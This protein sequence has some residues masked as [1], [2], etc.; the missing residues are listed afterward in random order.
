MPAKTVKMEE[1][2]K[3]KW[4][5]RACACTLS[6]MIT[7]SPTINGESE[8]IE[9]SQLSSQPADQKTSTPL[10]DVTYFFSTA[11][12]FL[13]NYPFATYRTCIPY[14]QATVIPADS[15]I[16]AMGDLHGSLISFYNNMN[17]LL[18][19]GFYDPYTG[20]LTSHCFL[21]FLGDYTDRGPQGVELWNHLMDL[22]I[23]NKDQVILLRGNHEDGRLARRCGF[24]SEWFKKYGNSNSAR[25]G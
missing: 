19:K 25:K 3:R 10:Y 16:I 11:Y 1:T 8:T 15:T 21:V 5:A 4:F 23:V 6:I 14:I 18:K 13:K 9:S 22:K 24:K 17:D 7:G 20:K 12:T 2:V